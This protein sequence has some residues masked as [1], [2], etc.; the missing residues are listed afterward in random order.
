MKSVVRGGRQ[1]EG[2]REIVEPGAELTDCTVTVE[3]WF[4]CPSAGDKELNAIR[5]DESRDGIQLLALKL[6]S[7]PARHEQR[8]TRR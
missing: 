4:E 3:P 7:L 8:R 2:E 5:L 6:K 1:L